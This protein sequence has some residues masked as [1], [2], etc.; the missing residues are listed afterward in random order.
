MSKVNFC[1]KKLK[2]WKNLR[3]V[4]FFFG[5]LTSPSNTGFPG[6]FIKHTKFKM[7]FFYSKIPHQRFEPEKSLGSGLD[8]KNPKPKPDPKTLF[9]RV[10]TPTFTTI[11]ILRNLF[12]NFNSKAYSFT[13]LMMLLLIVALNISI[14]LFWSVFSI[15]Y[16]I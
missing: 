5:Y 15:R 11:V 6:R 2:F 12:V 14:C 4:K 13:I 16:S 8:P 10:R 3:E 9:F 7:L 1:K